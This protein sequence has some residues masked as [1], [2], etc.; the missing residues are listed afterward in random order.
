[1]RKLQLHAFRRQVRIEEIDL[2]LVSVL[3]LY[4]EMTFIRWFPSTVQVMAYFI[5][6]VLLAAFVG[7]GL[8]CLAGERMRDLSPWLPAVFLLVIGSG[9]GFSRVPVVAQESTEHFLGFYATRGLSYMGVVAAIFVL[10]AMLFAVVGQALGRLFQQ[11]K[12]LTAYSINIVGSLIGILLFWLVS[13]LRMSPL[14]WFGLGM[15]LSLRV[16]RGSR[17]QVAVGLALYLLTLAGLAG[18]SRGRLWSPYSMITVE[19][20]LDGPDRAIGFSVSAN[21]TY[22]QDALDLSPRT[23]W[24]GYVRYAKST[25]EF[26]YRFVHPRN[27][28]VVGAGSGNDVAIG[29]QQKV[30]RIDAVEIDPVLAAM[31]S[32]LHPQRPYRDPR[33]RVVVDDARSFFN[34]G[35]QRYD[36]IAFG[37][38]D[39]QRL[40]SGFST[41]RLDNFIYTV[42]SFR[43][44]QRHLSPG[45]LLV[46]TYVVYRDWIASRL[47]RELVD[48]FGEDVRTFRAPQ[49][50][51]IDTVIFLA[52]PA[53]RT[54]PKAA[55]GEFMLTDQYRAEALP[56]ATDDWPYLYL[57][58]RALPPH[59]L[60]MLCMLFALASGMITWAAGLRETGVRHGAV[61]FLLGAA[62]M[63]AETKSITR[64]SLLYGSTWMVNTAVVISILLMVLAAN[65]VVSRW[66]VQRVAPWFALLG[67]AVVLEWWLAPSVYLSM[68]PGPRLVLSSLVFSL[69]LFFAAVIFAQLF[70]NVDDSAAVLAYNLGGAAFG[71][72]LEYMA[73][74]TGFR[75]VSLPILALYGTAYVLLVRRSVRLAGTVLGGVSEK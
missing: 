29:L 18:T 10:T 3:A 19:R 16:V 15:V 32:W 36:L 49:Y 17:R 51:A 23:D 28:L 27:A 45:G 62:F 2:F 47:E 8:G 63:L 70:S 6:V 65:T 56:S 54:I 5:N 12:P 4:L 60:I 34:R 67:G 75:A 69:P 24:S 44:A 61:F 21:Q 52:G 42:E 59:Y 39:A 57:R 53:A 50:H 55:V 48:V 26:P 40:L 38:L 35:Q 20:L 25:Y 74:V 64:F 9:I 14:V 46:V 11:F 33:V 7:L 31:G 22:H 73:M 13:T 37:R 71:G 66:R 30:Q 68:A 72:L 43:E 1:M 58:D 41:V